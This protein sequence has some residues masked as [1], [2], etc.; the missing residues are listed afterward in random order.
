MKTMA[1]K[2]SWNIERGVA[3]DVG[4]FNS[5]VGPVADFYVEPRQSQTNIK[6]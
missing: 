1:R 6:R 4:R 5:E 2:N 3:E